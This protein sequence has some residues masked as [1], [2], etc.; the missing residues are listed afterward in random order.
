MANKPRVAADMFEA[1]YENGINMNM[2]STS[3]IKI[4]VLVASDKASLAVKA[5][6]DKFFK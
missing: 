3:E 6:H 4:S 2:I 5:L 1:L